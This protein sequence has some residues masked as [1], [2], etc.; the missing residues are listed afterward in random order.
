VI[1]EHLMILLRRH[2]AD[3]TLKCRATWLAVSMR[4]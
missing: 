2:T 3:A 4:A 1:I